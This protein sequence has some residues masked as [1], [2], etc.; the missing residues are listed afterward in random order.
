MSKIINKSIERSVEYERS[1]PAMGAGC[2][3]ILRALEI[4]GPHVTNREIQ[5]GARKVVTLGRFAADD[6]HGGFSQLTEQKGSK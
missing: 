5:R 4:K 6:Q 3:R 2:D 1:H